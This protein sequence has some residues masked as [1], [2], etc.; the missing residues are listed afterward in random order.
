MEQ[1]GALDVVIANAGTS[2]HFH[3]YITVLTPSMLSY[4]KHPEYAPR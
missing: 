3:L 2:L 1:D 4:L